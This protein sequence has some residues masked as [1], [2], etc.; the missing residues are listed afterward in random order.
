MAQAQIVC[1][2]SQHERTL[3][4]YRTKPPGDFT[5]VSDEMA[6]FHLGKNLTTETLQVTQSSFGLSP[7]EHNLVDA[8]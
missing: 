3:A 4:H 1:C 8:R 7:A 6:V 5:T 2:P